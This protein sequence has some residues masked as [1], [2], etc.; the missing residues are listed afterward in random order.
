MALAALDGPVRLMVEPRA[1]V[2]DEWDAG[3]FDPQTIERGQVIG[4][5]LVHRVAGDRA[6]EMAFGA[7]GFRTLV[8]KPL[9]DGDPLIDFP[10]QGF[11]DFLPGATIWAGAALLRLELR[12]GLE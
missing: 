7:D 12:I 4:R 2:P 5:G 1:R 9:G 6:V 3:R 8:K 10:A 11:L